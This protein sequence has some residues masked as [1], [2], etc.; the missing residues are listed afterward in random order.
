MVRKILTGDKEL[1]ATLRTLADKAA[2]RVAKSALGGGLV[3]TAKAIRKAAP[4]GETG[5]LKAGIGRRL[6]KGKRGGAFVA[7]A[8]VNVGK[9]TKAEKTAGRLAKQRA[10]HAHLVALGTKQRFRKTIGGKFSYI[11]EPTAS[12]LSSGA[13]PKYEFVST[14]AKSVQSAAR[15]AMRK[16]AE[17]ALAREA[18]KAA[19]RTRS[20]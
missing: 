20:N 3:V 17:K 2:D 16:R 5:N 11:K 13:M 12:Q 9:R 8:G 18:I 19:K 10:P 4:V 7:K 14:A 6:E 15:A 1:E